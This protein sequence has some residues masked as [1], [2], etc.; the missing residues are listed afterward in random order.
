MQ[1]SKWF[2]PKVMPHNDE[3]YFAHLE[4]VIHSVEEL[5]TMEITKHPKSYT[6]RLAPSLPKYTN[7]LIEEI[8]KFHN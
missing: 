4:G 7:A 2:F 8:F 1:I 5:S 3:L 6:F